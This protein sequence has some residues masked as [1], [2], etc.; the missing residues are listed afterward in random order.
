MKKTRPVSYKLVKNPKSSVAARRLIRAAMRGRTL[1][2]AQRLLRLNS[3]NQVIAMLTG[4]IGD[5]PA[6][7]AA[8]KR[9]DRRADRARYFLRADETHIECAQVADIARRVRDLSKELDA[10]IKN[11]QQETPES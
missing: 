8:L 10:L 5:T 3:H 1:R 2:E 7:K 11:C 9:A 6:M 4:R